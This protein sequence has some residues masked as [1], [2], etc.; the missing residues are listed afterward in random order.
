[1]RPGLGAAVV[2]LEQELYGDAPPTDEAIRA[3]IDAFDAL[4]MPQRHP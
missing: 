4:V 2:A 3:A 1:M